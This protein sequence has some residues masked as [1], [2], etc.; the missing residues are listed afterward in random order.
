MNVSLLV[1]LGVMQIL[2]ICDVRGDTA[3]DDM[4]GNGAARADL[5]LQVT[6]G[7][8]SVQAISFAHIRSSYLAGANNVCPHP[9]EDRNAGER[10]AIWNKDRART[11]H[12]FAPAGHETTY[13]I[14]YY[15]ILR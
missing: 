15:Q 6:D 8:L 5:P 14:L 1:S 13:P 7:I 10:R 3:R 2:R 12:G 4:S 9:S 11:A